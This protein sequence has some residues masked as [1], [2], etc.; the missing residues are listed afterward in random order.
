MLIKGSDM[1][2]RNFRK[3]KRGIAYIPIRI[4]STD[5]NRMYSRVR[6]TC[7]AIRRN[8]TVIVESNGGI[9][10]ASQSPTRLHFIKSG[11]TV[12]FY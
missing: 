10:V 1:V 9:P 2:W 6:K 5:R 11:S 12:W 8:N 4:N 7:Q 3:P